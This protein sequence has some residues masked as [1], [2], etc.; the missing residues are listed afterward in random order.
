M[1]V[2]FPIL[3]WWDTRDVYHQHYVTGGQIV[4]ISDQPIVVPKIILNLESVEPQT[5][6]N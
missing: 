2:R 4:H 5:V 1:A 3:Y 6:E